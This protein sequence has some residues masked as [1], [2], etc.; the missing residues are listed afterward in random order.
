[1]RNLGFTLLC[2]FV[3]NLLFFSPACVEASNISQ[4]SIA[5]NNYLKGLLFDDSGEYEKAKA[6]YQKAIKFDSES[7]DIHYNLALDY[8]RLRDFKGAEKEFKVL[9]KTKPYAEKIRFLLALVY[10]YSSKYKAAVNEYHKLL[11]RPLLELNEADIRYSLAQLYFMQ[12]E[13]D[14]AEG[15][16]KEILEDNPK[17]SYAHFYLGYIYSEASKTD[18]AIKE[19][20]RALELNPTNPLALN[21]LSYLYA[22][23]GENLDKALILVQKALEQEPSNGAYL[24][25]LGWIYFKKGDL[26][27][28]IRYLENASVI[29]EDAEILEHLG[30]AYFKVG[31][32]Q[33]A[34]KNW[35]KSLEVDPKRKHIRDKII[36]VKKDK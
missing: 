4:E 33:Q 18:S 31:D 20:N 1:M 19:F 29:I 24:D 34:L 30:D 10:S 26:E 35:K 25:T 36:E 21:A 3:C 22:E 28:A 32:S 16:Y 27:K 15:E 12:E 6:A 11:E 14:R 17:D 5:Y 23:L 13:F 2:F 7:W 9:L 8:L